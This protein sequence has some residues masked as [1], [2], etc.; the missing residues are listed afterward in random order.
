MHTVTHSCHCRDF[1]SPP[2]CANVISNSGFELHRMLNLTVCL[3]CSHHLRA[4]HHSLP[5]L[6]KGKR[7]GLHDIFILLKYQLNSLIRW[8]NIIYSK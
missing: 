1:L 7:R 8:I 4:Y 2:M 6:C 3:Y 5:L